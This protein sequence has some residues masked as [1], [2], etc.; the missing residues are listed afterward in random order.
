M[1]LSI[2]RHA[3][4]AF[5]LGCLLG[6]VVGALRPVSGNAQ[7]RVNSTAATTQA[8]GSAL[9]AAVESRYVPADGLN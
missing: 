3:I 8:H 9:V 5:V 1:H 4:H 2:K 7:T 6:T